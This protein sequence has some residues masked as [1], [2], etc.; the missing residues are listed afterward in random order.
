MSE[1][2]SVKN[3]KSHTLLIIII[4]YIL[5][6]TIVTSYS[7]YF[8]KENNISVFKYYLYKLF[9]SKAIEN[10]DTEF[11]D[12]INFIDNGKQIDRVSLSDRYSINN[13]TFNEIKD[14]IGD[15]VY[16]SEDGSL[17][18]NFIELTYYEIEGL[19]NK[20]VQNKINSD[21]KNHVYNEL[22][23]VY[24]YIDKKGKE[25]INNI[26][27]TTYI[28]GSYSDILSLYITKYISLN[29]DD[30]YENNDI[31]N[32]ES[33]N[34]YL[35]Y[36]LDTGDYITFLDCFTKDASIKN[37]LS[38]TYYKQRAWYYSYN[39]ENPEE[40]SEDDFQATDEEGNII[41]GINMDRRE[42]GTIEDDILKLMYEYEKN[43]DNIKF[44]LSEIYL[45]VSFDEYDVYIPM[46]EFYEYIDIAKKFVSEESL[47]EDGN[48]DKINYIY[49]VPVSSTFK[50]F[51]YISSNKFVAV[52]NQ[53]MMWRGYY[54]INYAE[55]DPYEYNGIDENESNRLI[56]KLKS[57]L[58][59]NEDLDDDKGYIYYIYIYKDFD[60][61]SIDKYYFDIDRIEIN[62]NDFKET[63]Q[64]INYSILNNIS[65]GYVGVYNLDEKELKKYNLYE[66]NVKEDDFGN[67]YIEEIEEQ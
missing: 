66:Y 67:L 7:I 22:D 30:N 2:N 54:K 56:D 32:S 59:E 53:E 1:S 49:T 63:V 60:Y 17:E 58:N 18:E 39:I 57:Y 16:V 14:D 21:I 48:L 34:I 29:N 5:L 10:V 35:N 26:A 24:E 42:Y 51:D 11:I 65:E 9:G 45:S 12:T 40:Y 20:D 23:E 8:Y 19:K 38:K 27:I 41:Y 31:D 61:K 44:S 3:N 36:R 64:N 43:K 33:E 4:I 52:Q 37:I 47:Y 28:D 15:V 50:Y 6:A 55:D 25:N 62:I 13:I 46:Y